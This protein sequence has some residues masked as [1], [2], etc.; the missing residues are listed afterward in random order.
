M[1]DPFFLGMVHFSREPL[2]DTFWQE[3]LKAGFT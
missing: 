1:G 2:A 3:G